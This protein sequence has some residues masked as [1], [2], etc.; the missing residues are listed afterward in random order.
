MNVISI[1]SFYFRYVKGPNTIDIESVDGEKPTLELESE[2][3]L[4]GSIIE[5]VV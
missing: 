5:R 1:L 2:M 3:S 4:A